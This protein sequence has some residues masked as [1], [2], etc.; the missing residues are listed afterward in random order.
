MN[1]DFKLSVFDKALCAIAPGMGGKRLVSK[2][3]IHNFRYDG[4]KSD[5]KRGSA[6]Q[7]M[8]PNSFDVQRDR[9]QLM[10]EAEDMERNFAP[11]KMLNRKVA[12]YCTP[13]SYHAQT[14]DQALDKEIEEYLSEEAFP[15]CDITGRYDFFKMLEF[16]VM[17]CNRGGDYGWA[18]QRPGA[19]E[20]M[21]EEEILALPLK[22]QAVEP[23]RIGGIYQNVVSND[24][25]SGL[26]IGEFGQI[27]SFR[28]FHR[29]MTTNTYDNPIDVPA[30]DFVHLTDPM[31]IDQ[32]RGVSILATGI[33]NCRDIYEILDFCKGKVKL[34]S[35]LT[36]FTNSNG[37]TT[38]SGAFDPY[39]TNIGTGSDAAALQQD[40]SFGQINHLAGGTD[41]KFPST[42]SPSSEEQ[43]L[44]IQALKFI[45]MCY[46]LPYSFA[47][48]AAALG[49]VSSR[50]ESEMAKATFER[51]QR[52]L[53]PHANRMKNAFLYDAIA[54][55]VFPVSAMRKITRGRWGYRSHPQP[56]LGKEASAAV[57]LYQTGLLDPMKH[58]VDNAQDPE[59]VARSMARW[60]QIKTKA[61]EEVGA[62]MEDIFGAGPAK[63]TNTTE[64]YSENSDQ[65]AETK[66]KEFSHNRKNFDFVESN[67][68]RDDNGRFTGTGS[69]LS[70]ME[71][72]ES[73]EGD[74]HAKTKSGQIVKVHGY[75]PAGTYHE[76]PVFHVSK[77][78]GTYATGM[79][80]DAEIVKKRSTEFSRKE[81]KES[82]S[83][84]NSRLEKA[85][86][87]VDFAHGWIEDLNE[88]L[89]NLQ[90]TEG[91]QEQI[92]RLR[93]EL[94]KAKAYLAEHENELDALQ[95]RRDR[96]DSTKPEKKE[97]DS[98]EAKAVKA[99]KR[100]DR[101]A[102]VQALLK[103]GYPEQRAYAI[104]YEIM[105]RGEFKQGLLPPDIQK[106]YFP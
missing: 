100:D 92:Q 58:W 27:E 81:F 75:S 22:I 93:V 17:G 48:D 85:R 39:R 101:H 69:M 46:D 35:A 53:E 98:E 74:L 15:H 103:E 80:H 2:L 20:D 5:H 61:A 18:F 99:K 88:D 16:G 71:S 26:N 19:S 24:Y 8:S 32:Y 14:G 42:S 91:N 45:A 6:P 72:P 76:K 56:D 94:D 65:S 33:Q 78:D 49:G 11:A 13:Q 70:G 83:S 89:F 7:N 86:D 12:M 29:S 28:V 47:L 43:W 1:P 64:S 30:R 105:K 62:P 73:W 9:L 106:K 38:G 68:D 31:R 104:S 51:F 23:D 41:I 87:A 102:L 66:G 34:A 59:D 95:G 50:L 96:R 40:I 25:V 97:P 82:E 67:H 79:I 10:R 52:V 60:Y 36:V 90:G 77:E 57:N 44:L 84:L 54:K 37:G 21:S 3:A 63:P 55:G 4:A